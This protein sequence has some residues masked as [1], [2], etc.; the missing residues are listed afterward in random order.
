MQPRNSER[1]LETDRVNRFEPAVFDSDKSIEQSQINKVNHLLQATAELTNALLS[2]ENLDRGVNKALKIL[3]ASGESDRLTVMKHH[4]DSTGKT[5]GCV[6]VKY[7]W[8]S[9]GTVSQFNH[10]QLR[11]ISYDGIE[12]CFPLFCEGEHWGGLLKTMPEPFRSK[13]QKLEV[14][15]TYAIPIMVNGKYW[16]ILG[17]DFC[18]MARELCDAE[19]AVLK[20]AATC[21]GSAIERENSRC[22]KEQAQR[23]VLLKQHQAKELNKRNNLLNLTAN[24]A[25]A[26]LNNENLATA[27]ANALEII[28]KGIDADRV[29]VL[30]HCDDSTGKSLGYVKMLFEWHSPDAVSQLNHPKLCRVNYEG[31]EDWYEQFNQGSSVGGIVEEFPEPLRSKQLEIGVKSLYSVPIMINGKYWG[32]VGFDD[33]VEA[34]QRC[35]SEIS[36]LKTTAACIGSAIEQSRIRS[37]REEAQRNIELEQQRVIQLQESNKILYL[38]DKWLEATANAASKLLEITDFDRGINAALKILGE[39][40]DCDRVMVM[41]HIEDFQGLVY[42]LYEWDSPGTISQIS[43]PTLNKISSKGIEDWFVKLKAGEWIGGTIDEL[44][45]PFRNGQIELG[46]QSTYSVPIF[47]NHIY[48]GAIGIDFCQEPKRLTIAEIAVF[49]TAASCIG[50]AI[51]GQQIQQEKQ[52]VELAIL[53]ERNRMAREIHDSL[54]QAFTGISLQLEAAKN[55]LNANPENVL[56]RLNR[57]KSLAKEGITEARRSVR[58]LRPEVLEA[59]D[60]TIALE[61]LIDK[62]ISGTNIKNHFRIEGQPHSLIPEIQVELFRIAQEAITNSVRHAQASEINVELI[63]ETNT[64]H[65]LVKDNG[66]GFNP[67]ISYGEGFGLIGMRQRSDRL[68]GNLVINSAIGE[69]TEVVVTAFGSW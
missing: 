59:G 48:W 12:E 3:G 57:A 6:V 66:K 29:A 53:D 4:S 36:I 37:L 30:E 46:V 33:C 23:V 5:L 54:A 24:V 32:L 56:E 38:R 28:G 19:I 26:L 22:A 65:L 64:I 44:K 8:L 14:K 49:K 17:F 60:L 20:T 42:L 15:A 61:Q 13:Q 39:S 52:K 50:S 2:D 25:Q 7:E 63:Y 45:E 40:L 27:I 11:R 21:I 67:Q 1:H 31:I 69:G 51:Y 43:H 68:K 41:H 58:A 18:E 10:S 55:A 47:V 34:K 62:M 35:E 9:T 16:G